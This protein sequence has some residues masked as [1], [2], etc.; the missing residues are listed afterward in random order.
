MGLDP[1]CKVLPPL[2]TSNETVLQ[3]NLRITLED[4]K[5]LLTSS[6]SQL[7]MTRVRSGFQPRRT[8]A[9]RPRTTSIKDTVPD[10][11]SAAPMTH[12]IKYKGL[13]R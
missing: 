8:N 2:C 11:G 3:H 1:L 13:S 7:A 9:P 10:V 4:D 6:A 12:A 5:N